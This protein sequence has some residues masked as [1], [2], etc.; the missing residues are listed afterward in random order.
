[1]TT[2]APSLR[3]SPVIGD[4]LTASL[5]ASPVI[6]SGAKQSSVNAFPIW[7]ASPLRDSQ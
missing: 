2:P 7:I 5:R 6:A 3:A 4:Y 1:M